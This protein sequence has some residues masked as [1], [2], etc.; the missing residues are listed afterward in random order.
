[1]SIEDLSDEELDA[2]FFEMAIDNTQIFQTNQLQ[3]Q[4]KKNLLLKM[5]E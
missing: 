5:K 1:M 4:R 2:V 3:N